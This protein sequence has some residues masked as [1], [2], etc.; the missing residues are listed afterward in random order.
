MSLASPCTSWL[1]TLMSVGLLCSLLSERWRHQLFHPSTIK[2]HLYWVDY[3][4]V[5][6]ASGSC[7]ESPKQLKPAL[8]CRPHTVKEPMYSLVLVRLISMQT[9]DMFDIKTWTVQDSPAGAMPLRI[10]AL[11]F[12]S[13][14]FETVSFESW[15]ADTRKLAD[16]VL[17]CAKDKYYK[18]SA[19]ALTALES[20]AVA[21][22]PDPKATPPIAKVGLDDLASIHLTS[23][24]WPWLWNHCH[25]AFH[26]TTRR[27][28]SSWQFTEQSLPS[29][30]RLDSG[31]LAGNLQ[32]SVGMSKVL[33]WR[34]LVYSCDSWL[35]VSIHPSLGMMI[36]TMKSTL[37]L[38]WHLTGDD[39]T[40][41][42]SSWGAFD[43]SWSRP[44]S[45]G[46]CNFL[47]CCC[48]GCIRWP[49]GFTLPAAPEG[50]NPIFLYI[51]QKVLIEARL[52]PTKLT[53]NLSACCAPH[54]HPGLQLQRR[55]DLSSST[56]SVWF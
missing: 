7:A 22:G 12:L 23:H 19:S 16:A 3:I 35:S 26:T 56:C 4:A 36:L 11:D 42:S 51:Q 28:N 15:G 34:S 20:F 2:L 21:I 32:A 30:S 18:I 31:W 39:P 53:A 55:Y 29:D 10:Q 9:A 44:G 33:E 1:S 38:I 49:T 5:K 8:H 13:I 40:N 45:E 43:T 6:F 48:C 24:L 41:L 25:A 50:Q 27:W 54:V 17:A 52:A 37:S 46:G 47:H 14:A